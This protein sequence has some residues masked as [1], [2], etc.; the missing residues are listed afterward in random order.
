MIAP[1]NIWIRCLIGCMLEPGGFTARESIFH[2]S[3]LW[4]S[5]LCYFFPQPIHF[6]HS[7]CLPQLILLH[8][9]QGMS[10]VQI[11][12]LLSCFPASQGETDFHPNSR[13]VIGRGYQMFAFLR[14]ARHIL[15]I[16]SLCFCCLEEADRAYLLGI[17]GCMDELV[18]WGRDSF[19]AFLSSFLEPL[20]EVL[21]TWPSFP[22]SFL[23]SESEAQFDPRSNV[24][25]FHNL[26]Q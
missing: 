8:C 25:N 1:V 9:F 5:V 21:P 12:S 14:W 4:M 18:N 17:W 15:W 20:I 23:R 26:H 13:L 7:D 19:W 3:C 22:S 16:G 2:A 11:Y 24:Q 10:H 6:A